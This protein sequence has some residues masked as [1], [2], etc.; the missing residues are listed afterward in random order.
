MANGSILGAR[1]RRTLV[2]LLGAA[3]VSA[4]MAPAASAQKKKEVVTDVI[5]AKGGLD[6]IVTINEG[7]EKA[8]KEN[9]IIPSERCSD[10]EFIRR[11]SL[12]IIGRIAKPHEIAT[13][14]K[15]P[16]SERRS[17]LIERLLSSDEYAENFANIW[18]V[19]L[20]TRTGSNRGAQAQMHDWLKEKLASKTAAWDEIA[21]EL[22]TATGDTEKNGAVNYVL[23]HM[24]MQEKN[25]GFDM[26]PVTSRT[27]KLFLG[28]QTQ[29]T[30]CHDHP[31]TDKWG[32]HH[33]WGINAFFRQT[34]APRG[35]PMMAAKKKAKVVVLN[36][37]L[38]DDSNLNRRGIVKYERRSGVLLYTDATFL[39]GT[40]M[41]VKEGSTRREELAKFITKSPFFGKAFV[42]RMWGHF[43]GRGFTNDAIDDFG[44]HNPVAPIFVEVTKDGKKVE[45][46]LLDELAHDW[47]TDYDHNPKAIIRWIC[48]S[49]AYGLSSSANKSN[50]KRDAEAFFSRVKMKAMSPEQL[51]ESLMV[52]TQSKVAQSKEAKRELREDWLNKLIQN[53]GDDEGNEQT[54]N[55]TVVQAL[56]LMNGDDINKAIMD[57]QNGTVA[58]VLKKRAFSRTAAKD[59]MKDLFLATLNRPPSEEEYAKILNA[60]MVSLPRV[61]TQN[62]AAFW[63]GF[64]QDMF[65]A[66]LN[67]NEFFLNH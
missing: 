67:S 38:E 16:P 40:K 60:R 19:L 65:W 7:L 27:T 57:K 63:T 64:Y 6:Q 43:F 52:A 8:W 62:N 22:I 59:A 3:V 54:F 2:L 39:D 12:D 9:N 53:F 61:R 15:D 44:E 18:T 25:S 17:R 34:R 36:Y 33:F 26:V 31:F 29:C 1:G 37:S 13:Y 4:A 10:Y 46:N 55:G 49:R 47:V 21:T 11:A 20:L 23:H 35:R 14:L 28:L 48:N 58:A 42:N 45:V 50:Y 56:M 41:K 32:Q 51:F 5:V 30:Q 66:L 24:G